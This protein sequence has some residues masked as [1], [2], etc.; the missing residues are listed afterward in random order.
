MQTKDYYDYTFYENGIVVSKLS[1]KNITKRIGTKGYYMIN[2]CI[3]HKCKTF[4]FHRLMAKL[5]IENPKNLPC[6]NH[7]DGNKLNNSL[8]NLEW[9][10]FS[11]N[12]KHAIKNG[13][14]IIKKGVLTK[15]GRFSEDDIKNIRKLSENNISARKIA[16]KYNVSKSAIQQIIWRKTYKWIK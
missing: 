5:F 13:L 4:S 7:I 9:V 2:L 16:E 14:I 3:N 1:G 15:N 8:N 6:V 11:E 12:T 10:T